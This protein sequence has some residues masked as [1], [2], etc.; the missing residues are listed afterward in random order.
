MWLAIEP[1]GSRLMATVAPS[2]KPASAT[3]LRSMLY[4]CI[5]ICSADR[6][7]AASGPNCPLRMSRLQHSAA[8]RDTRVRPGD[9]WQQ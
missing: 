6:R 5:T 1:R 8:Q 7:Y 9:L 3:R 4:F 2:E